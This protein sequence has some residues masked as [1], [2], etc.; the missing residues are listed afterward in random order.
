MTHRSRLGCLVID[1]PGNDLEAAVRFWSAALG[2]P[3]RP[4]PDPRYAEAEVRPGHP[5]VVLQSVDHPAR[6]H[7]DLETDDRE[8]ERARLERPGATVVERHPKGFTIMQAPTGQRFCLI[9][10]RR[11][12]FAAAPEYA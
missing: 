8:A 2:V 12:D 7:L 3:F 4:D 5:A 11:P 1:C 6:V 10:P 9:G